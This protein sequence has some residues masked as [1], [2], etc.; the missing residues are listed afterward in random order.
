M[1]VCICNR[2]NERMVRAAAMEG[3]ASV[4]DVHDFHDTAVCCGQC[5]PMMKEMLAEHGGCDAAPALIPA[6]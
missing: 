5:V 3:A 6:E 4:E 2:I 1:I